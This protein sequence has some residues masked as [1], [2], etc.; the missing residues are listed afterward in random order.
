MGLEFGAGLLATLFP[1]RRL[2]LPT[3][4]HVFATA[5][6][7][8]PG[9]ARP[10]LGHEQELHTVRADVLPNLVCMFSKDPSQRFGHADL[11]QS[12]FGGDAALR[13]AIEGEFENAFVT[14]HPHRRGVIAVLTPA[15]RPRAA[16]GH[17]RFRPPR[18][19]A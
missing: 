3:D 9:H 11:R 7:A 10:T 18:P 13:P 4:R 19:A 14:A 17:A 6:V 1:A 5:V 16:R 2:P 12:N 15:G 8:L